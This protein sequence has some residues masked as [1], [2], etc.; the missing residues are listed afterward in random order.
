VI[1]AV[2]YIALNMNSLY[3]IFIDFLILTLGYVLIFL[4]VWLLFLVILDLYKIQKKN[5]LLKKSCQNHKIGFIKPQSRLPLDI[6]FG[7][8]T[9]QDLVSLRRVNE[10][11]KQTSQLATLRPIKKI[12]VQI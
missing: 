1:I 2:T 10:V 5:P 9:G 6:L 4:I 12:W 3:I 8:P 7:K 11:A